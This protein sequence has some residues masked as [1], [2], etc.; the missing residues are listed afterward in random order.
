MAT[1]KDVAV[2]AGVSIAT[3]SNYINGKKPVS[4]ETEG[5][6]RQ[7]IDELQYEQNLA[8]KNLRAKQYREVGV[9]LPNLNDPYYIQV[10]QGIEKTLAES[11]YFVNITFSYDSPGEELK[12]CQA[13]LRKQICGLILVPCRPDSWQYYY[14]NFTAK[15]RPLVMIDRQI[16][17]LDAN[18]VCL[19]NYEMIYQITDT[20][21]G[22]GYRQICL[23]AR[24]AEFTCEQN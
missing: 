13:L 8:A 7:A 23:F 12:S 1:I 24:Y 15:G 20:L 22:D 14:D 6:I 11:G 10:F 19:D 4:K 16:K 3:V 9:I 5:K 18:F 17:G 21:L 2:L